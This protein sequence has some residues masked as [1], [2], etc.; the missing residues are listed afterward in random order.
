MFARVAAFIPKK[1]AVTELS[2][3]KTYAPA[4]VHPIAKPSRTA[5]TNTN[6]AMTVYSRLRNAIAPS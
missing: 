3:P 6:P 1:P 5:T 4:G 2:A